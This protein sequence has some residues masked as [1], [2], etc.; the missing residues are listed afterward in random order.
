MRCKQ[1]TCCFGL[2]LRYSFSFCLPLP[3]STDI[4]YYLAVL[5]PSYYLLSLPFTKVFMSLIVLHCIS[6]SPASPSTVVPSLMSAA[7]KYSGYYLLLGK[8]LLFTASQYPSHEQD[9]D[10]L[11]LVVAANAITSAQNPVSQLFSSCGYREALDHTLWSVA[12]SF[13]K[14]KVSSQRF[15]NDVKNFMFCKYCKSFEQYGT[16]PYICVWTVLFWD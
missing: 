12:S 11:L 10:T 3:S 13:G 1:T 6:V 16:Q 14:V 9:S 15:S 4:F 7:Y 8:F 5:S 2:L